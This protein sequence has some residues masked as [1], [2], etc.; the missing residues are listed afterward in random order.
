[1][2]FACINISADILIGKTQND[3]VPFV[4]KKLLSCGVELSNIYVTQNDSQQI[5]SIINNINHDFVIILGE[6]SAVK[7]F[8]IKNTLANLWDEGIEKS[9]M[10][11]GWL[12]SYFKNNNMLPPSKYENEYF[13]INNSIPLYNATSYLQ[14]FMY[15]YG[16]TSYIFMPNDK[17]AIDFIFNNSVI[18][19]ITKER[20]IAYETITIN[21]FG[22]NEKDILNNLSELLDN[23][24]KINISTYA[25]DLDVSI[26]V[27]YNAL[28]P[29]EVINFFVSKIYEKL[30][31]YIYSDGDTGLYQMALDLLTVSN[32]SLAIA[33]TITG[34]NIC[35]EFNKCTSPAKEL[36]KEGRIT[37]TQFT[38]KNLLNI[39]PSI[40]GK[41]GG[42]SVECAY[43]MA[44][45]L[46][47]TS[48]TDLVL[49]T[50]GDIDGENNICY[51]A[52]GDMDGIHV[53]KNT[54]TGSKNKVINTVSK[55]GVYYLIKKLKQNDLYFNTITV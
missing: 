27:R 6:D 23:D 45:T 42:I 11:V 18:P 30:R 41:N 9:D 19:I 26:F 32:K 3:N 47:E 50:C 14:G 48:K 12:N 13:I 17:D 55:C 51:I 35:S 24:Y 44:T 8:N 37:N 10:C 46:L 21:T 33:E 39:N 52:V 40:G 34:G 16:K 29:N 43:E 1:M 20:Q 36:I 2:K 7:N 25:N 38:Q 15:V 4:A 31:K 54:Y 53:Y 49:I 28:T 22:I 5:T